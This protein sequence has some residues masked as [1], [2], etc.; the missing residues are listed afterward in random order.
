MNTIQHGLKQVMMSLISFLSYGKWQFKE[1]YNTIYQGQNKSSQ[2]MNIVKDAFGDEFPED[3]DNFSYVTLTDLNNMAD[4]SKLKEGDCFADLACGRGGPGMWVAR[5][6]KASL[7]GIDISEEAITSA[8][9]RIQEFGLD[10]RAEFQTGTFEDTG[11]ETESCDGAISVDALWLTPDRN[12]AFVEI[13]RILKPGARLV[14]TSWDGNIPFTPSD[15]KGELSDSGFEVE[16]YKET[17]G[18]KERQLAVYEGVLRSKDQLIREMGK[19]CAMP[20]IKEARSTPPVMEKSTR[21]FVV[22]RKK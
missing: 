7:T 13:A 18:W 17:E 3:T 5:K 1:A 9:R 21:I 8:T 10:G 2:F 14:F 6:T 22:A 20:I 12:K 4:F 16:I 19:R 11:L 15:H